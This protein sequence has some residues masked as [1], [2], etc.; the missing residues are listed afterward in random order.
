MACTGYRRAIPLSSPP[1]AGPIPGGRS[2]ELAR[3]RQKRRPSPGQ[4]TSTKRRRVGRTSRRARGNPETRSSRAISVPRATGRSTRFSRDDIEAALTARGGYAAINE[5]KALRPVF[6]HVAKRK[7]LAS[8]PTRGID[9]DKSASNGFS[10]A[11]AD[12]I[13][14]YQEIWPVG[15][16]ERLVFDLALYTGAARVDLAR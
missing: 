2:D 10:T 16:T 14:Q 9:L 7:L 15:T 4:S 5:L 1:I 12:E 13:A 3:P 6:A 11:S 8:D